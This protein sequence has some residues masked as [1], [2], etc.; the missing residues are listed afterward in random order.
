ML[1]K[2]KLYN[3]TEA[4]ID[5]DVDSAGLYSVIL[6]IRNLIQFEVT[7]SQ[8]IKEVKVSKKVFSVGASSEA[9]RAQNSN[10]VNDLQFLH[11]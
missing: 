2:I 10:F 7:K 11:L 6:R 3:R 4:V 8:R 5:V 1:N 9:T